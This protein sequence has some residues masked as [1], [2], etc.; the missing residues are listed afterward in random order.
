[1]S[2]YSYRR[3]FK[4]CDTEMYW[5]H[6]LSCCLYMSKHRA[7]PTAFKSTTWQI[8]NIITKV[9]HFNVHELCIFMKLPSMLLKNIVKFVLTLEPCCEVGLAVWLYHIYRHSPV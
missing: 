3:V 6:L 7:G 2:T 8:K 1:M 5:S 9:C 4:Q